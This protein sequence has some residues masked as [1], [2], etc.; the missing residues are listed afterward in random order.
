MIESNH[1]LERLRTKFY[2]FTADNLVHW[3]KGSVPWVAASVGSSLTQM[4]H[5]LNWYPFLCSDTSAVFWEKS[6]GE[7]LVLA[8]LRPNIKD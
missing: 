2:N 3:P 6:R 5:V 4:S 1:P 8:G 7:L